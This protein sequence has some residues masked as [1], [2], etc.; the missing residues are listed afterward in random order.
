LQQ[1]IHNQWDIPKAAFEA[2]PAEVIRIAFSGHL[3][4]RERLRAMEV[5][6]SM[7]R[8]NQSAPGKKNPQAKEVSDEDS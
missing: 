8:Q 3:S 6:L 1:A 5:V 4:T 2:L 7:H